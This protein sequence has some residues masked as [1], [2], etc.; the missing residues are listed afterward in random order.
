M[1]ITAI[2]DTHG[3][4]PLPDLLKDYESDILIHCGDFT[5]GHTNRLNPS[6]IHESH[7]DSWHR[8]VYEVAAIKNQFKQIIVVP[9]N[10]DQICEHEPDACT[11]LLKS[12][13]GILLMNNGIGINSGS[14]SV[15]DAVIFWGLPHT[16][17]FF[18]WFFQGYDMSEYVDLIHTR[19][20]VIISHG[21]P[22]S[23]L[24]T[25]KSD[26]TG[27]SQRK[28]LGCKELY[29]RCAKLPRLKALFCGHIH[30]SHGSE[31]RKGVD[32]FNCSIIN[33]SYEVSYEPVVTEIHV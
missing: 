1:T 12:A 7:R 22:H 8:F 29:D 19:T 32:Y 6:K 10:H 11:E 13:G 18:K 15:S 25:V 31:R 20:D 27:L 14:L 28:L 2:S 23:I 24:D 3:I 21:P 16:P 33:E 5:T 26:Y 4:I 17:P 30:S 9:G